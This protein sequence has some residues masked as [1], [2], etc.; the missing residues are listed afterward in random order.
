MFDSLS[1]LPLFSAAAAAVA[2]AAA[3]DF[4]SSAAASSAKGSLNT[5]APAKCYNSS[6]SNGDFNAGRA[7]L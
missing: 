6:M 4:S 7:I 1:I 3:F 2:A 5:V